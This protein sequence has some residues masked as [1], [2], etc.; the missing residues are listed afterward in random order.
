MKLVSISVENYR[1]ISKASKIRL[2]SATVLIGPNN[3]GKSNI[4][5]ALV[6]AMN[7]LTA[8]R[9]SAVGR[10][11][12][13]RY[14]PAGYRPARQSNYVW[15]RDYPVALQART[16]T[17]Q[18]NITLEF[19]LNS[20]ELLDFHS[21]IKSSLNGTLPIRI[22]L[23]PTGRPR[24][25]V[26]KQGVGAK[27]LSAKAAAISEFVADRLDFEYIPAV[28]TA[29][30]AQQ[31]VEGMV[32]RELMALERNEEYR[33][34]LAKVAELQEPLLQTLSSTIRETL[35]KFLPAVQDVRVGISPEG[36]YRALRRECEI[37]VDDGTPTL[38][39]A[40]GDGV[41]SLAALGMMR[42]ASEVGAG[43]RNL[44]IAIEEPESHLH[45]RAIHEF[46]E[47]MLELAKRHQVIIT[48][49]NPLFVDRVNL[50]SNIIVNQ[51]K[52]R[53]AQNLEDIRSILG[54][55]A[56][57]N[58]RHAELVLVVE[59]EEDRTAL[60]SLLRQHSRVLDAAVQSGSVAFDTLGGA[61]NLTYKLGLLRDSMCVWHC[62]LDDDEAGRVAYEKAFADGLIDLTAV[63]FSSCDG[64]VDAELEDLYDPSVYA[65]SL[66]NAFGVSVEHPK[67]RGA[68]K[69]SV[70]IR[71]VF[72]GQGKGWSDSIEKDVKKSVARAVAARP[73][74]A[75]LPSRRGPFDALVQSLEARLAELSSRRR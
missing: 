20:D 16:P 31:I 35:V 39:E 26:R 32:S 63:H 10:T 68:R 25:T 64:Q 4:L 71:D 21:E 9:K 62:F 13:S 50:R 1:S 66:L 11:Y 27:V 45:P 70:R 41:Q 23:G 6:T 7:T 24:I 14:D 5:R 43:D 28:R 58:L 8:Q 65:A 46:K 75:L 17:G 51:T 60:D 30:S 69:W 74:E 54:V 47:V 2:G 72:K 67:F 42:H 73:G 12:P 38:L 61:G 56:A 19:S 37:I 18:S 15:E 49:H 44:V 40:K 52:A 48:S 57:D 33:A 3:E 53:P 34:A 29:L 36:R 22:A 55:R 59:G